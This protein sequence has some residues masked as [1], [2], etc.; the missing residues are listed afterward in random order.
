MASS[1]RAVRDPGILTP[2]YMASLASLCRVNCPT[3]NEITAIF[4]IEF[5]RALRGGLPRTSAGPVGV[6]LQVPSTSRGH[7]SATRGGVR[8]R[9]YPPELVTGRRGDGDTSG[10]TRRRHESDPDQRYDRSCTWEPGKPCWLSTELAR[11][12]RVLARGCFELWEHVWTELTISGFPWP[13]FDEPGVSDLLRVS[14]LIHFLLRQHRCV[15]RVIINFDVSS[16]Q[17]VMFW[18]A[19]RNGTA[20]LTYLEFQLTKACQVGQVPRADCIRWADSISNLRSLESLSI[21]RVY[22]EG[23]SAELLA[24]FLQETTTLT[25]LSMDDVEPV[26]DIPGRFLEA[27]VLN[28]T[29]K[30]LRLC[31][32]LLM[33]RNGE[34]LAKFVRN[35][36]VIESIEVTGVEHFSPSAL[37]K[38]AVQSPSLRRLHINSCT[39]KAIDI[40]QMAD[41]LTRPPAAPA[42]CENLMSRPG[43][44]SRRLEELGFYRCFGCD[45]IVE[46]AYASLIGGKRSF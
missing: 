7:P 11:W 38:A 15:K 19:I 17:D 13:E 24:N 8:F 20:A 42:S 44:P 5:R 23:E 4:T 6:S 43:S 34:A 2:E 27:L 18:D 39:I 41:D 21:S 28:R 29:L 35:H 1:S 25:A 31:D 12:N 37:L 40:E 26:G 33:A 3:V 16:L 46:E 9:R 32:T 45:P 36:S 30:N 22:F 14:L 10:G